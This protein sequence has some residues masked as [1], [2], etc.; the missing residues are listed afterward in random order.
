MFY[1]V[2]YCIHVGK[3][4]EWHNSLFLHLSEASAR[5]EGESKK[6]Y[7]KY[8]VVDFYIDTLILNEEV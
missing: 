3:K 5:A 2:R 7:G 1:L 8:P 4:L 6:T